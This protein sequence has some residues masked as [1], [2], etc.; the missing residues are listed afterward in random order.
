MVPCKN[1]KKG[2]QACHNCKKLN[3]EY[4]S[5]SAAAMINLPEGVCIKTRKGKCWC[6]I[7]KSLMLVM[8]WCLQLL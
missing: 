1:I 2:N 6:H 7:S 4:V 8:Q 5:L 3:V